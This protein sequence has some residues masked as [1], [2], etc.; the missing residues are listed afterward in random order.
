MSPL[1]RFDAH[2]LGNVLLENALNSIFQSYLRHRA[3]GAGTYEADLNDAVVGYVNQFH[4]ST[5]GLQAGTDSIQ[6]VNYL[7]LHNAT[8]LTTEDIQ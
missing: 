6:N 8:S 3:T 4:V 2:Y 7:F 5:V 1:N